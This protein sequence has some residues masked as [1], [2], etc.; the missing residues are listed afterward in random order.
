[1]ITPIF[2]LPDVV[3]FP[4]T[5]LPLHIFEARYRVMTQK[6]LAGD[7]TIVIS[8]LRDGVELNDQGNPAVHKVACLGRIDSCKELDG[9]KYNIVLAGLHRVRLV[10][11]IRHAPYRM[12]HV[13]R[14]AE[15]RYDDLSEEVL[16]RRERLVDLYARYRK[17]AAPRRSRVR[18]FVPRRNFEALVN[19][20]AVALL[21]P[22][23][24]KQLLLEIDD[25]AERC[26]HVL[27]ALEQHVD[28]LVLV[29]R[30]GHLKPRDP[31][32]N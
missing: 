6:A 7:G 10:R 19:R 21:L 16:H 27:R 32:R 12:A 22:P 20:V 11:E 17:L 4:K 13:E 23:E 18:D 1:M 5:H 30:Y 15:A 31:G 3:L 2:P 26:D 14:I 28:T 9:G 8:L 25:I 29:N 24:D